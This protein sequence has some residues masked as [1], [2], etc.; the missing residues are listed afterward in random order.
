MPRPVLGRLIGPDGPVCDLA[1]DVVLG[2]NPRI[3]AEHTGPMPQL[4]QIEDP[5]MEVSAPFAIVGSI[6]ALVSLDF[7]RILLTDLGSTNGTEVITP[8]GRRQRLLPNT[9]IVIEPGTLVVLAEI[10][11]LRLEALA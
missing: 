4:V 6:T 9:P 3:P 1:R 10:V 5:R 2:R 11:E 7:W 8:D